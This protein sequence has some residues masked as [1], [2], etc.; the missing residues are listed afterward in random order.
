MPDGKKSRVGWGLAVAVGL[1]SGLAGY[2]FKAAQ[3]RRAIHP[4]EVSRIADRGEWSAVS[5]DGKR[6]AYVVDSQIWV[7]GKVVARGEGPRWSG[8]GAS[9][10]YFAD[11]GIWETPGKKLADASGPGDLSH[12]GDRL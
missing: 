7:D 9:L 10:I 12:Q 3:V 4:V 6:A 11:G 1:A 5:P 8:E 2:V